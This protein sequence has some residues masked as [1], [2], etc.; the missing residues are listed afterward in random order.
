MAVAIVSHLKALSIGLAIGIRVLGG[1][2]R[3]G[4]LRSGFP[5]SCYSG[6]KPVYPNRSSE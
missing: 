1:V 5:S 6:P 3:Y 4:L 2:D